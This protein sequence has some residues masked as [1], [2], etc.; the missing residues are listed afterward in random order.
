M[1]RVEPGEGGGNGAQFATQSQGGAVQGE[2]GVEAVLLGL[3]AVVGEP[4][5]H[6]Q[7]RAVRSEAERVAGTGPRQRDSASVPAA[8]EA[9]A[10]RPRRVGDRLVRQVRTSTSPSSSPW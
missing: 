2:R 5:R 7:P 4:V 1:L 6:R 10:A 9:L 8:D 3:D